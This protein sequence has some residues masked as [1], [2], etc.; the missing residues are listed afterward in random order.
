[1]ENMLERAINALGETRLTGYKNI[2]HDKLKYKHC[3]NNILTFI[4]LFN[5]HKNPNFTPTPF[6]KTLTPLPPSLDLNC[7]LQTKNQ[8]TWNSDWTIPQKQEIL[9]ELRHSRKNTKTRRDG[10]IRKWIMVYIILKNNNYDPP[11]PLRRSMN[12]WEGITTLK[13]NP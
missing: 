5:L 3:F 2:L 1:M 6:F 4:Q 11:P 8:N 7:F 10:R 12:K 13:E 9:P